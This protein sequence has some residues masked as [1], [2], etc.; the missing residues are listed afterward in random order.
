M[1]EAAMSKSNSFQTNEAPRCFDLIVNVFGAA[2]VVLAGFLTMLQ[3]A[4]V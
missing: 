1:R 4:A 2:T 3:F